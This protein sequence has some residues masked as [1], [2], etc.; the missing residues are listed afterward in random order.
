MTLSKR[1]CLIPD[2]PTPPGVRC[3]IT[4]R[5][6]GVSKGNLSSLNLGRSVGD[7]PAA[8]EENRRRVTQLVGASPH[9]MWQVHGIEVARLDEIRTET[10]ITADAAVSRQRQTVCAVMM[11]DCLT[12]LLCNQEGTTVAAAH[13]GWRGLVSGVLE[14]TIT[15]MNARPEN[16]LAFMG[17]AIGPGAFEVGADVRDRFLAA[18]LKTEMDQVS[19]AFIATAPVQTTKWRANLYALAR[20]RMLRVGMSSSNIYGGELC[21]YT[22]IDRFFSYRR[23]SRLGET[24]GR[25]AAMIWLD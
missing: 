25:M 4:T 2:W 22:D 16:V 13:A 3:L 17:P 10:P 15:A 6:G 23:S 8:V 20:T 14:T 12:V 11:A 18:A 1:D 24:S 21:T 9:W 5:A 7:D 19:A